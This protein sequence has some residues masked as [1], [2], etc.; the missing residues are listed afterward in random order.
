MKK[1]IFNCVKDGYLRVK[2][3][4]SSRN[5]EFREVK[6]DVVI[7]AVKSPPEDNE[8]NLEVLK[9]LKKELGLTFMIKSGKTGKNKLLKIV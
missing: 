3:L 6:E 7:I 4:P 5:T 9:F 1:H 8:A 2:V